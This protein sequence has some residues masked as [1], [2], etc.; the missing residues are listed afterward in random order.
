MLKKLEHMKLRQKLNF[1]YA[2]VIGLMVISGIFSIVGLGMLFGSFNNY[3]NGSQ[4]AD[5]AVKMCRIDINIAAR[6]LREMALNKDT[7]T[8]SNYEETIE[9]YLDSMNNELKTLKSTGVIDDAL[10]QDYEDTLTVWGETLYSIMNEIKAGNTESAAERILNECAPAL[11]ELVTKSIQLDG[12]TDAE[13]SESIRMIQ[14]VVAASSCF[15]ILFI[16]AA[17]IL[18]MRIGKKISESIILPIQQIEEATNELAAGNLHSTLDYHSEDEMGVLAHNLR[19]SIDILS[20]YVNDI[21]RAMKEFSSGNFNVQA[22]VEWKGDFVGILDSFMSFERSMSDTVKGIQRVADQVKNGA[23]QVAASSMDLAQGATDQ[24]GVTEELT[25][26]VEGISERVS[27]NAES[28]KSISKKVDDS[29]IEIDNSNKKMQEMLVSMNEIDRSSRE[30]SKII[31]TI[32]DIASQTNLLAL[33][34]SIEAARA[35]EAGKGFAVVA[36]QVSVLA[37]QSAEAAK[38]STAL[39]ETSVKAVEK[40][41]IIADETAEQLRNVVAGSR[42]ITDEVN[43]VAAALKEQT[44]YIAQIIEGVDHINDV[45]Q[46]NSATSE[47]CAAA[48]QEMS[49]Q[50]ETLEGLIRKFKV[51]KF[52]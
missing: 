50:A 51:A 23:E 32:N 48:S 4:K 49:S 5:T 17:V 12:I 24:A 22:E 30:I 46:T 33:N 14:I 15:I 40:G 38:E 45:V 47:E 8:Y 31:A 41:K 11:T 44:T 9:S 36:D 37:A 26:T 3:V 18:A 35:G 42:I 27:Q 16:V 6:N 20:S 52:N 25:A 43:D 19:K 21:A 1:G 34:A 28:A 39:I 10:Y 29:G 7:G 13:K 2:V